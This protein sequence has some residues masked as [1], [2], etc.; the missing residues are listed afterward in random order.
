MLDAPAVT[1]DELYRA[2]TPN[3]ARLY[4]EALKVLPGGVTLL[5][6]N[7]EC[8]YRLACAGD[9]TTIGMR[10]P[11]LGHS[12]SALADVGVPILQTSANPAGGTDPVR[13][14]GVAPEIREG[15]DLALDGGELPGIA[16]TVATQ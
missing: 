15:A 14:D 1:L 7:P 4:G 12:I 9:A 11:K 3:S 10:V 2:R 8:R 6:A 5:L 16:S 13:L